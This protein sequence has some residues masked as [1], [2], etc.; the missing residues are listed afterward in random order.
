MIG[1]LVGGDWIANE[2]QQ[3]W[4]PREIGDDIK[5]DNFA[6]KVVINML[7]EI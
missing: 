1:L 6:M 3:L 2:S 4:L 5:D 7:E